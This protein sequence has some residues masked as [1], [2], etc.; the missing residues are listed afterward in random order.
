MLVKA[1]GNYYFRD[2]N[3]DLYLIHHT[4]GDL[5]KGAVSKGLLAID[6]EF[7]GL[8]L[9]RDRLCLVQILDPHS[10][11]VYI[12]QVD[13]EPLATDYP[14][15]RRVLSSRA[16]LKVAHY[17]F[18]DFF[19]LS[20]TFRVRC[21][22]VLCTKVLSKL[23]R[24]NSDSHGLQNVLKTLLKVNLGKE[25]CSSNWNSQHLTAEQLAYACGDV[26]YLPE[27]VVVLLRLLFES[28]KWSCLGPVQRILEEKV[29]LEVFFGFSP[30]RLF[31]WSSLSV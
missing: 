5:P 15:L 29:F 11:V 24:T 9:R 7:A 27:L 25:Q 6:T 20:K 31:D 19:Q 2:R 21:R 14:E 12:L 8:N 13:H 30:E 18:A 28:G 16:Y 17:A 26:V 22:N 1:D 4:R 10:K 3:Q 23:A